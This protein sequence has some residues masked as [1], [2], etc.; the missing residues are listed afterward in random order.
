MPAREV[1]S[2]SPAETEAL[3][4]ALGRTAPAGALLGLVGDLGT[5]KTCLVRGLAAGLGADPTLVASPSF[6]IATEYR[7]GRLPLAHVDVYR[8]ERPLDDELFF[9]D[10][11][12]GE[13]VAAVE[14]FDRLL[15]A[16]GDEVL[17]VTLTAAGGER[18]AIRLEARGPRH[19]AWLAAAL[20]A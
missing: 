18:R 17:V 16:A 10:V 12:Y 7:G 11:L 19:A 4:A 6:V 15:P 3:G 5:G 9:R 8:L 1:V 20:G 2:A 13:G 14:W